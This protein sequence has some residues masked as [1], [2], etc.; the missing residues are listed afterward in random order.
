MDFVKL[1]SDLLDQW[2]NRRHAQERRWWLNWL[3]A[4]SQQRNVRVTFLSGDPH[5]AG[6]GRLQTTGTDSNLPPHTV[7]ADFRTP[8]RRDYADPRLM[9]GLT[10]SAIVNT[11]PPDIV[12]QL[13]H[14][15]IALYYDV[16]ATAAQKPAAV[17]VP[18]SPS[19]T[20]TAAVGTP[21]L[22]STTNLITG[23]HTES[24]MEQ[25]LA[26]LL[27]QPRRSAP[28]SVSTPV[29][30]ATIG[31]NT[32]HGLN[33]YLTINAQTREQ[34]LPL[35]TVDVDGQTKR[36]ALSQCMM[37]RRNWCEIRPVSAD[38]DTIIASSSSQKKK[39]TNS[40]NSASSTLN[41]VDLAVI[42]HVENDP[43]CRTYPL[44]AQGTIDPA[45]RSC[46]A[47]Q[48]TIPSLNRHPSVLSMPPSSD[49]G[50]NTQY[51]N[52]NGGLAADQQLVAHCFSI[53]QYFGLVNHGKRKQ[54][55]QVGLSHIP[56]QFEQQEQQQL[57]DDDDDT[58]STSS[59]MSMSIKSDPIPSA[60]TQPTTVH[61]SID[62][63][64]SEYDDSDDA[65]GGCCYP[66]A[67]DDGGA[68]W[69]SAC[70]PRH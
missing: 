51:N 11:P 25:A 56:Q 31:A 65:Y 37:N 8:T 17:T 30:N 59:S 20:N 60:P 39:G 43:C 9:Y 4:Y 32:H 19:N 24:M 50:A 55:H 3:Q 62:D 48:L 57:E 22:A 15:S 2:N 26:E 58:T 5:M 23:A 7:P 69:W 67:G 47:Y 64:D 28:T 1:R 6:V 52:G 45:L 40:S 35:F 16:P 27:Q 66:R 33:R 18:P 12:M 41:S 49:A 53:L 38:E 10:S 63:L 14:V 70:R 29:A 36:G 44:P 13:M 46:G 21:A 61:A 68:R 42:I 34:M 54:R